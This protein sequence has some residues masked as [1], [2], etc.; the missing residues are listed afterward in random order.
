MNKKGDGPFAKSVMFLVI[1]VI[2]IFGSVTSGAIQYTLP[3]AIV[4]I[5]GFFISYAIAKSDEK[6]A[7]AISA[8]S[9]TTTTI[10]QKT[11]SKEAEDDDEKPIKCRFCKKYYSS[12]YN[13]CPYCKKK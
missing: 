7:E 9:N 8:R 11:S 2:A 12:E 6:E 10:T 13:G 3:I 4:C 1:G 5:V